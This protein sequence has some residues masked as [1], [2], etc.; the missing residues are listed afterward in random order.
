MGDS[1]LN[2]AYSYRSR[3]L[4]GE[5]AAEYVELLKSN[6][7]HSLSNYELASIY[8]EMGRLDEAAEYFLRAARY[9]R[10]P[11]DVKDALVGA[12][13]CL[14]G[15]ESTMRLPPATRRL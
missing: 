5:A 12:A 11:L 10:D 15:R 4:L 9:F 3:G 1:R 8:M 7:A 14:A 2:L 6:P 13:N